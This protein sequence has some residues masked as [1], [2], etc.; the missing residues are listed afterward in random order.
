MDCNS[1]KRNHKQ[2]KQIAKELID[3]I[4]GVKT[5]DIN[6]KSLINSFDNTGSVIIKSVGDLMDM[7]SINDFNY[8]ECLHILGNNNIQIVKNNK[9]ISLIEDKHGVNIYIRYN[10]RILVIQGLILDDLLNIANSLN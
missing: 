4:L 8:M 10:K 9:A 6:I 2:N 3:S 1:P 5:N 7:H